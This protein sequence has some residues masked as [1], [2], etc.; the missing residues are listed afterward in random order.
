MELVSTYYQVSLTENEIDDLCTVL[1]VS[2]KDMKERTVKI[3]N[4]ESRAIEQLH[5]EGMELARLRKDLSRLRN[6]RNN[7]GG[8]IGRSWMGADA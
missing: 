3:E 4:S 6:L 1:Q 8:L 7:F 5:N 2:I